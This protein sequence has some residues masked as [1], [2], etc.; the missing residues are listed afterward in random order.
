MDSRKINQKI[1]DNFNNHIKIINAFYE[2]RNIIK[3]HKKTGGKVVL[4]KS[5]NLYY[6]FDD[7]KIYNYSVGE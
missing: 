5:R 3:T 7:W 4:N 6:V 2:G 1:I